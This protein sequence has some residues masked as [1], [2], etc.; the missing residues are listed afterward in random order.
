M[1]TLQLSCMHLIPLPLILARFSFDGA[2]IIN[3]NSSTFSHVTTNLFIMFYYSLMQILDGVSMTYL[4]FLTSR[5]LN[6]TAVA[7]LQIMTTVLQYLDALRANTSLTCTHARKKNDSL[8]YCVNDV[9]V[10]TRYTQMQIM[11]ILMKKNFTPRSN[12][13][14]AL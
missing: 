12:C 6:G 10:D 2:E 8:T 7:C 4:E 9:F 1:V 13:L 11:T 3:H 5:K 14:Q